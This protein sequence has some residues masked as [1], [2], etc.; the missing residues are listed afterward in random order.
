MLAIIIAT[1]RPSLE[2]TIQWQPCIWIFGGPPYHLCKAKEA[3]C[4]R[5]LPTQVQQSRVLSQ[6]QEA[7]H[8]ADQ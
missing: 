4:T 1:E 2:L 7:S 3:F 8:E 6:L 5:M